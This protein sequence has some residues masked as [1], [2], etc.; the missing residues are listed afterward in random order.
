MS[1]LDLPAFRKVL[2]RALGTDEGAV[3]R[4]A[5]ALG[6]R[7]G[8]PGIET[9]TP[10][11]GTDDFPGGPVFTTLLDDPSKLASAVARGLSLLAEGFDTYDGDVFVLL[12]SLLAGRGS[13]A[14]QDVAGGSIL[15]LTGELGNL[16]GSHDRWTDSSEA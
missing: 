6:L 8:R 5:A 2:A 12:S 14:G 3:D 1:T 4:I 10:C 9:V 7:D 13:E 16:D 15:L 11:E